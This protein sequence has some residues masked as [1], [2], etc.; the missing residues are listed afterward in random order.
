MVCLGFFNWFILENFDLY[1]HRIKNC[2]LTET[3]IAVVENVLVKE[4]VI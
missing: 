3:L 1:V 4:R 2:G